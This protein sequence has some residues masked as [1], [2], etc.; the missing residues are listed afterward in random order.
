M[1]ISKL[2]EMKGSNKSLRNTGESM[3][4]SVTIANLKN[5]ATFQAVVQKR[6]FKAHT[7]EKN[8]IIF[9]ESER[10]L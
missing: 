1:V 9:P 4:I 3:N 5:G 2:S 8:G 7:A 6:I 10:P